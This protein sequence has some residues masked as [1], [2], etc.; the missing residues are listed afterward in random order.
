[1]QLGKLNRLH[2]NPS[3]EWVRRLSRYIVT[4]HK[5]TNIR[6]FVEIFR[7]INIVIS[8]SYCKIL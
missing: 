6:V 2:S 4:R 5:V 3:A 7:L 8:G 1:L